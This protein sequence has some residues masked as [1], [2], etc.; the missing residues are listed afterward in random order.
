[1]ASTPKNWQVQRIFDQVY[2]DVADTQ[3]Y[4]TINDLKTCNVSMA[5]ENVY[6]SGGAGNFLSSAFSHSKRVTGEASAQGFKHDIIELI[7]GTDV[8]TGAATI[9]YSEVLTVSSN[10][11]ASTYT[12]L[13]T[14]GSEITGLFFLI[15][16]IV[17]SMLTKDFL[18]QFRCRRFT[19]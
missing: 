18:K 10:A 15:R 19:F 2:K 17:F 7:T 8:V 16:I 3:V 1:M 6:G 13:G 11:A 9:P 12:A 4:G 14:A 5:Q